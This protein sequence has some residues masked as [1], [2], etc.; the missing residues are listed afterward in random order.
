MY[1]LNWSLQGINPVI[2]TYI[3]GIFDPIEIDRRCNTPFFF[4]DGPN[5]TP[6]FKKKTQ[7]VKWKLKVN[8]S[9]IL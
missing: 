3:F 1:K 2:E 6:L 5:R 9:I 7:D 8:V 4:L